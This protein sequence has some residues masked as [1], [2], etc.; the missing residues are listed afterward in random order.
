MRH[1]GHTHLFFNRLFY[2]SLL[3]FYLL[4]VCVP[5][6]CSLLSSSMNGWFD[7]LFA[8]HEIVKKSCR[9]KLYLSILSRIKMDLKMPLDISLLFFSILS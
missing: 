3:P 4:V 9:L 2:F 8:V 1:S 7:T 6:P 5:L